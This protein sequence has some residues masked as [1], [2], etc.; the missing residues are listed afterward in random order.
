MIEMVPVCIPG[1]FRIHMFVGIPVLLNAS[2][3]FTATVSV[4]YSLVGSFLV[5]KFRLIWQITMSPKTVSICP[6]RRFHD[7]HSMNVHTCAL[8]P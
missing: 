8:T 7:Y 4:R 3:Q 2:P 5:L 1:N 6:F